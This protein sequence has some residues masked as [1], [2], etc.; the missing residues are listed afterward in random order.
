MA[1]ETPW[2]VLVERFGTLFGGRKP[3]KLL[4]GAWPG[5]CGPGRPLQGPGILET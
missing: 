1:T 3:L 4:G 5:R 2:V